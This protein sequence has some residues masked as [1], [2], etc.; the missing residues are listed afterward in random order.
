MSPPKFWAG[1]NYLNYV[2]FYFILQIY[3]EINP[4]KKKDVAMQSRDE[5]YT[6]R[7]ISMIDQAG[8]NDYRKLICSD[9]QYFIGSH[10]PI[11]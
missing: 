5:P 9:F 1:V 6:I 4:F 7:N 11:T 2:N 3:F 10:F 8:E